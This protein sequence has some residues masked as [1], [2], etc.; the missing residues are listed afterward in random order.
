MTDF[1]IIEQ[2]NNIKAGETV[3][4]YSGLTPMALWPSSED[5]MRFAAA[6]NL[7]KNGKALLFQ[8]KL[9]EKKHGLNRYD[10]IAVGIEG[11]NNA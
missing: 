7:Q 2:L 8:K 4:Y 1:T 11:E 6:M 5:G 10:Y 3:V 9:T